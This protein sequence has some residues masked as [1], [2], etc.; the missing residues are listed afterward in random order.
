MSAFSKSFNLIHRHG[1][2]V[3]VRVLYRNAEQPWTGTFN[4]TKQLFENIA[5]ADREPGVCR[6]QWSLN[7]PRAD[8][9]ARNRLERGK[10]ALGK[11][12][13]VRRDWVFL[14]FDRP[15]GLEAMNGWDVFPSRPHVIAANHGVTF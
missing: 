6:V 14:D 7:T 9:K 2:P 12:D 4:D 11:A 13:I 3:E 5:D 8:W 1:K 10:G 15:A